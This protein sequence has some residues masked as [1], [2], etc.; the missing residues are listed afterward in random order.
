MSHSTRLVARSWRAALTRGL[1]RRGFG[2][3]AASPAASAAES[4]D[5]GLPYQ[6]RA[7]ASQP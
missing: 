5:A 7:A 1:M 6:W 3:M 4:S 2:I